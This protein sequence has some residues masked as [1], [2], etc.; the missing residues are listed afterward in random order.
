MKVLFI[1]PYP[2]GVAASQRFRVE[3]FLP[4]LGEEK[5][6]YRMASFWDNRTWRILYKTGY[7][8]QKVWGLLK[9]FIRRLLLLTQLP[10]YDYIFI[11]REATPVGPPW[12][13]WLA[14]K[15]FKKKV[16]FDMD[17]ALWLP[18]TTNS[19]AIA[20][21]F[22]QH[23]KVNRIMTW[24]YRVSCGNSYL[25]QYAQKF[26]AD[27]VLLPTVVDTTTYYRQLKQ[28]QT[29]RVVIG[30]TGS[31]S[32]LPFLKITE[33]VL[34]R[35]EKEF[36]FD[37]IV[38]ADKEPDLQLKSL[39][40]IPWQKQTEMQDLLKLNIG[41]MP[42]PTT[43]WAKGKCAFKAIQYMAL[44][45]PAVVSA[46][47]ANIAAVPDGVA[48]YVCHSEEAWYMHLKDL[49]Q[50]V[51]LRSVMGAAGREWVEQQYAVT[52]HKGTFLKLFT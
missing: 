49:L 34:Q 18:N 27:A 26:N 7:V 39:V 48:G 41:I 37:F 52:A 19:N 47:G 2:F 24:S 46:V 43:E 4:L 51:Q 1:V 22:K 45:I 38:V 31:H 8:F 16:I 42:L 20:A 30:W 9:G 13:E 25:L 35:L 15:V 6:D 33:P 40:F 28:Q 17:D 29:D 14:G 3:Q 11:H 21:K 5:V 32:T 12:F 44:G 36:D 50:N 10:K 23:H